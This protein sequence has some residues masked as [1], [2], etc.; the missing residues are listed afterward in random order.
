MKLC[1]SRYDSLHKSIC[2][3]T[4]LYVVLYVTLNNLYDS[5]YDSLCASTWWLSIWLPRWVY[6]TL[7]ESLYCSLYDSMWFSMAPRVT[8][9]MTLYASVWISASFLPSRFYMAMSSS[10]FIRRKVEVEGHPLPS[11]GKSRWPSS[12]LD[13]DNGWR[14]SSS[15]GVRNW[16]AI[17]FLKQARVEGHVPSLWGV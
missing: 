17:H 4:I 16:M 1:D 10:L 6:V 11:E 15:S 8:S 12:S 14:P 5:L 7:Y 9:Y 13:E 2:I 3:Y